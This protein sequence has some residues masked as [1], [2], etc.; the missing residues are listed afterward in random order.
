MG[1]LLCLF[2]YIDVCSGEVIVCV[3]VCVF[4]CVYMCIYMC[5]CVCVRARSRPVNG[6]VFL[7]FSRFI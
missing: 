5:V 2:V 6:K 7:L 3:C 4:V 1:A